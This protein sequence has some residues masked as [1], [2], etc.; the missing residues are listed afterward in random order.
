VRLL[1]RMARRLAMPHPVTMLL[2]PRLLAIAVRDSYGSEPVPMPVR[3]QCDDIC[4]KI[5]GEQLPKII[6]DTP[7]D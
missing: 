2:S 1:R 4:L 6:E 7:A 3:R 5:F